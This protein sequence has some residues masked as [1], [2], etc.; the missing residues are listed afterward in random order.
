[1]G[2]DTAQELAKAMSTATVADT[3]IHDCVGVRDAFNHGLAAFESQLV[4]ER[5]ITEMERLCQEVVGNAVH[6]EEII[7]DIKANRPYLKNFDQ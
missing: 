4:D 1:M 3:V 7:A 6:S 5:T 2:D